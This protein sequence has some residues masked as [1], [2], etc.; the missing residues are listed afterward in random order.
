MTRIAMAIASLTLLLST[1][2]VVPAESP[3]AFGSATQQFGSETSTWHQEFGSGTRARTYNSLVVDHE[4]REVIVVGD[5]EL[6]RSTALISGT[7]KPLRQILVHKI[8]FGG[9]TRW[10]K[11]FAP[12]VQIQNKGRGVAMA[13]GGGYLVIG[14]YGDFER[15]NN[16]ILKVSQDGEEVW[17]HR[18][19]EPGNDVRYI[20]ATPDGGFLISGKK[21]SGRIRSGPKPGWIAKFD[22]EGGFIGEV[23]T[24]ELSYT[25]LTVLEDGRILTTTS[26]PRLH[27][28]KMIPQLTMLS[29]S[30]EVLWTKQITDPEGIGARSYGSFTYTMAS[31]GSV[32]VGGTVLELTGDFEKR[33]NG[34]LYLTKYNQDG[35]RL[36]Y[37]RYPVDSQM[38]SFRKLVVVKDKIFTVGSNTQWGYPSTGA[39]RV[40]TANG[41]LIETQDLGK[42]SV[43]DIVAMPDSSLVMAGTITVVDEIRRGRQVYIS[44]SYIS[45]IAPFADE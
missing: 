42:A 24:P 28:T 41:D 17:T 36:W 21:G 7:G 23:V 35:E 3:G 37:K 4:R 10:I 45:R 30:G 19:G 29:P 26:D 25:D 27:H 39:V 12:S 1:S 5:S 15:R 14:S 44:K 2:T 20:S 22:A 18:L 9:N 38:P 33:G 11:P 6:D 43:S 31:D 8:D 13:P 16:V 34:H 32:F 40:F